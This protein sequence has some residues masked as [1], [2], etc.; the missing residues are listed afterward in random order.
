MHWVRMIRLKG[1]LPVALGAI[2]FSLLAVAAQAQTPGVGTVRGQVVTSTSAPVAGAEVTLTNE[3]T[4][5]SRR[6][7]TDAQGRYT[8]P[9]LPLT[10]TYR[11]NAVHEGMAPQEQKGIQLRGGQTATIDIVLHPEAAVEAAITVYGTAAGVQADSSQLGDHFDNQRIQETPL[12][13]RKL[14]ALPLLDS[15]VR[16]ARGTGDLFLD[17]TLFVI[18][19]GGRRQQTYTIDGSTAD[20]SWGRQTI[21]TAVP[22]GAIQEFTVLTNAFSAEYGR[23]SGSALNLVTRSGTNDARGDLTALYRPGG[24]Q[25]DAPVTEQKSHDELKQG[26]GFFSGPI[27]RDRAYWSVAGE[28]NDQDR[29]S[30]ITSPL[31]PG[32]FTGNYK[33]SLFFARADADLDP[34]NHLFG[35]FDLDHFTDT[36]PQDVVGGIT[37]PSAGRDFKRDTQAAQV[38]ETAVLSASAYN[39]ARL[40]WQDGDPITQFDPHD[41]STQYV[42]PGVSTEGESRFAKLTNT[43]EQFA[44]TVSLALGDQLLELG[45]DYEHSRSGGNGQEFGAPFVLGQFTFK[46]G[47]SPSIPTSQL[48]INDVTR[49]TQGFGNVHYS[50]GENLWSLFAQDDYR[51]RNNLTLNLGVR[52]DRQSLN[53]DTNNVS[54]RLGFTWNPKND[55]QTVVRGGYGI[56]YSEIQSNIDASWAL[57]GP[58]GFFNFGVAPGQLGFPT[59]L[60]PLSGFPPGAVLPARDVTIRPGEAGYYSQ[61]FDTSKLNGYPDS[62][63]NPRTAQATLGAEHEF[64]VHWFLSVDGVHADSTDIERTLDL[65]APAEFARNAPGQVRSGSAADSTRPITPTPNGYRRIL[66]TLNDGEAKYDGLQLNLRKDFAT[67]GGLWLSYTWSHTRNNVEPDAPGG[68]PNDAHELGKEWADSLLDQRHRAVLSGWLRLPLELRFGGVAEYGTGRPYNITTGVDNNGDGANTDRPV[69]DGHVIGRN[70]GRGDD[71]YQLTLFLERDFSVGFGTLSLRGEV[72]NVTNHQNVVGYN[73]V[74]G[75]DPSGKP[76]ATFGQ[77]LGGL[78]NVD[79]GREYQFAARLRF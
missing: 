19:G 64:G 18:N 57:A 72:F 66:A 28:Y 65:N 32:V 53:D 33:Q 71:L 34:G 37:L 20:D 15:A 56:Y 74:Y 22:L 2:W 47:I 78:A 40:V 62:F 16:S 36:N 39:D 59:T 5:F 49:F 77:P 46:P 63:V 67:R 1:F 51:L 38:G 68:D 23:S 29:D 14:T 60:S 30:V 75:N 3:A 4:G 7:R 55:P 61:F 54:P 17:E 8:L 69:I 10:G 48:T 24:L 44:D 25:S 79:P 6:T 73:G 43:E 26:S 21:F 70:A 41:P 76:L 42:R 52:Y 31:A 58:T 13:G 12:I 27:V 9:E 11:I 45:G 35:R 50:V